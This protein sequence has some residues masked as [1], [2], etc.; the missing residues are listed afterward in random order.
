M[1]P[2]AASFKRH[3][4]N[5]GALSAFL[6]TT[7]ESG[8]DSM[9][10][11]YALLDP[12]MTVVRPL[13]A[14][15]TGV[16]AGVLENRLH[17]PDAPGG[18]P[19]P[20]PVIPLVSAGATPS[21]RPPG[22]V[23]EGLRYALV[24]VWGDIVVWFTAGLLLAGLITAYLPEDLSNLVLGGGLMSMLT[25]LAVGMPIYICAT[26]STPIAAALLLKGA[27][28]GAVLVFLLAGPATNLTS[29]SV[30]VQVL[31]KMGTLRYLLVVAIVSVL[32]G[33]GL[34]KFYEL[35]AIEPRAVIGEAREL[36]P[37]GVKIGSA[38]FLIGLSAWHLWH[39]LRR[40]RDKSKSGPAVC[41]FPQPAAVV[42]GCKDRRHQQ[43]EKKRQD[44][45]CR[46]A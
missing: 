8:V 19:P 20:S 21:V 46:Q 32:F 14:L 43:S 31:G 41:G 42:I 24:D 44:D 33:L 40:R 9:A 1:L 13:A 11:T 26:A 45:C 7:P 2:A 39:Y 10:I 6:V 12:I 5:R 38:A 27:S 16:T 17:D 22:R 23:I 18:R 37:L 29:L 34:D 25:M 3:G 36:L 15:V 35:L 30:L 4:A 28:P